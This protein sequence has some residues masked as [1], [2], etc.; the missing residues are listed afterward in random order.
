MYTHWEK[1]NEAINTT[2]TLDRDAR[3]SYLKQ[4]FRDEP[5]ILQEALDYLSFIEKAEAEQFLEPDLLSQSR[6]ADEISSIINQKESLKHI[7]GKQIGPYEITEPIGEGGMGAVYLAERT[8]GGF[9]QKVAIKFMKSGFFSLYLRERFNGEK[10]ILSKLNHPNI[11][12]L[13]D[14]G[15]T[16]DGSPYFI[17]EYVEGEP[18]DLFCRNHHLNLAERISLFRDICKAV[19]H[20]H[21]RFIIHR[22]LKPENI[23][24]TGDGDVKVMDF[25]IAKLL[26]PDERESTVR[27]REG[28][29]IASFDFAAPEQVGASG[30]PSVE[31][32]VYGLGA[33]LYLLCTDERPF[34]FKDK[35]LAEIES[36]IRENPPQSPGDRAKD[37]IGPLPKDLEAIILKCLRKEPENRYTSTIHLREDVERYQK[38]WP[39]Q[40]RKGTFRYKSLK[41]LK[42]NK[43]VLAATSVLLIATVTFGIYHVYQ[44]NNEREIAQ[45][46][47]DKAEQATAFMVDLFGSSDP[48]QNISDT[49]NVYH[50]LE[51]GKGRV[52]QLNQQPK[53]Q[54]SILFA[55]GEAY[56]RIGEYEEAEILLKEADSLTNAH[57]PQDSFEVADAALTLGAIQASNQNFTFARE[58]FQKA[59]EIFRDL[60][61]QHWQK[62]AYTLTGYGDT[63]TGLN[64]PDSAEIFIARGLELQLEHQA[65]EEEILSTKL[66]LAK[67]YRGQEK[68]KEAEEVYRDVLHNL[69][70]TDSVDVDLHLLTLNNLAYLLRKQERFNEAE[71]Y[72]RRALPLHSEIYGE[73]HPTTLMILTNLVAVVYKQNR[74][75]ET[76]TLLE[77]NYQLTEQRY[78]THWRTGVAAKAIGDFYFMNKD[79]ESA[80]RYFQETLEIYRKTIGKNHLW[81]G[82]PLLMSYFSRKNINPNTVD[83]SLFVQGYQILQNHS[84]DFSPNDV[85]LFN[86][87]IERVDTNCTV[88]CSDEITQLKTLL[89][90]VD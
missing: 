14:G 63:M 51:Q 15:I 58:Y 19:Q 23:Y 66:K 71:Q 50:L 79:F 53:L 42:R 20:A 34:Q 26:S 24:I 16:D 52:D 86:Q 76:A 1:I 25:G 80:E 77:K 8:E 89:A 55:L 57:Y 30:D 4:T 65:A 7:I 74:M 32:D 39:V 46:E 60:P 35:S 82:R 43:A 12:R 18:V 83:K 68:N 5:D 90:T 72:Y 61:D 17:M 36:E 69:G 62:K 88:D 47:A 28:Q 31:T 6:L 13:L 3:M 48:T 67:S 38:G 81:T 37:P 49:L 44:L 85:V 64:K 2:L 22:D 59:E 11:A 27:T 84:T 21:S 10:Q 41:F 40:A 87:L 45:L 78:G 54:A 33:L 56:H 29:I 75:D 73:D 70:K 9:E